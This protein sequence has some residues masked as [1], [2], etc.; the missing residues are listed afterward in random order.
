[1]KD[2]DCLGW[3]AISAEVPLVVTKNSGLYDFL[4]RKLGYLVNGLCLSVNI[5]EVFDINNPD[6]SRKN[7]DDIENVA[8]KLKEVLIE[9][10]KLKVSAKLLKE[11]KKNILGK[12]LI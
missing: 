1:M 3:E 11:R 12:E 9:P 5:T 2:L 4:H 6:N 10:D 7:K 8:K